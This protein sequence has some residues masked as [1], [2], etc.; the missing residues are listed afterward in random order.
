MGVNH[1]RSYPARPVDARHSGCWKAKENDNTVK[2]NDTLAADSRSQLQY[3]ANQDL[4]AMAAACEKNLAVT[5]HALQPQQHER[6]PCRHSSSHT[7]G[8]SRDNSSGQ[9]TASCLC[10]HACATEINEYADEACHAHLA[11]RLVTG[12]PADLNTACS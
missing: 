2:H 10:R 1:R 6:Q 5:V 4:L 7:P 9:A 12:C 11:W 8:T 3:T